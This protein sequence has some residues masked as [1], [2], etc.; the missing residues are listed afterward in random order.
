MA[1]PETDISFPAMGCGI[2]LLVGGPV[3]ASGADSAEVADGAR[4][5][6][7]D[8]GAR[9]SRF[10]AESELSALNSDPRETVPVSPLMAAMVG[11]ALLAAE[12]TGGLVDPTLVDSL[13][14][15]GY[16]RTRRGMKSAGLADALASA[17]ARKPARPNPTGRWR[18]VKVDST[19]GTVSRPVGLRLDS[20]GVGKGLAADSVANLLGDRTRF[21]VNASGDLRIGGPDALEDPYY[22]NIE[23]PFG[24]PPMLVVRVGEGA[25]ATSGIDSRLW[26]V[27]EG[28]YAHHLLDPSTGSPAWTGIVQAT[29]FAATAL[30]A[31]TLSKQALLSGPSHARE[32]LEG[33]GGVMVTD[34]HRIEAIGP[35][36][37]YLRSQ[38]T[39]ATHPKEAVSA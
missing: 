14:D 16:G 7:E 12:R 38:E 18:E 22:V 10:E 25:V 33:N 3:S 11:A 15:V 34:D 31:E 4:A 1:L 5:M 37:D 21:C 24:G 29:A 20:G 32:I 9:L 19:A 39:G 27:G 26:E 13:E 30:E 35:V 23:D 8:F 36:A 28:A 2:R 6:I 17:P